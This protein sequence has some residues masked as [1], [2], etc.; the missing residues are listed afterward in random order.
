MIATTGAQLLPSESIDV[1]RARLL[2]LAT[3]LTPNVPEA[4]HLL[5]HDDT[6]AVQTADDL[7]KMAREVRKLGPKWVLVKGGHC[8][9]TKDG[10]VA[11]TEGEREVV[12]DVLVGAEEEAEVVVRVETPYCRTKH[13]HGT[14]CSLACEL[15]FFSLGRVMVMMERLTGWLQLRS[16][17]T[18][19]MEW[20]C[21]LR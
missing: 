2:P 9:F 5:G 18:W 4:C 11:G 21:R 3:V 12:V 16:H 19:Q 13:T 20:M 6:L 10:R 8:P 17:R 14:G 15:F 7:E 1:L